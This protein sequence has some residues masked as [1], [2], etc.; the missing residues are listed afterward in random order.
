MIPHFDFKLYKN[1]I[2]VLILVVLFFLLGNYIIPLYNGITVKVVEHIQSLMLLAMMGYVYYFVRTYLKVAAHKQFW[3]W[4]LFWWLMILGRGISWGRDYLPDSPRIIFK[5]IAVILVAI[6]FLA[7]F[8]PTIRQEIARRYRHEMIPVWSILLVFICFGF[9][10]IIEHNRVG[11]SLFVVF[12]EKGD[13]LEE[14]MEIPCF[15]SLMA[16]VYYL[17]NQDRQHEQQDSILL[18]GNQ[19][20]AA[21]SS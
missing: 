1:S 18:K 14:L 7:M 10:D 5:T 20:S 9:S 13:L 11:Y 2:L 3:F 6:P 15:I 21:V 8:L 16:T 19:D 17:L 12:P 4:T